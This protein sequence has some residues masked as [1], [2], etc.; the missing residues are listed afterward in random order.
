[1]QIFHNDV[2][3]VFSSLKRSL[4]NSAKRLF[5][6]QYEEECLP[7]DTEFDEDCQVLQ[8]QL[9]A[10]LGKYHFFWEIVGYYSEKKSLVFSPFIVKKPRF[11]RLL[12]CRK[13][14]LLRNKTTGKTTFFSPATKSPDNLDLH[15]LIHLAI[16]KLNNDAADKLVTTKKWQHYADGLVDGDSLHF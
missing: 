4:A 12:S 6:V 3:E 2:H 16:Y 14:W 9:E 11:S 8:R 13:G 5:R 7:A 10:I 1:M 15:V